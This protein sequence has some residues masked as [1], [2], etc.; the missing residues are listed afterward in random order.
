[1]PEGERNYT[2]RI[3]YAIVAGLALLPGGCLLALASVAAGGAVG[4]YLYYKYDKGRIYRDYPATVP[5]VRNA[6]HAALLDLHFVIDAD[7]VKDGNALV[8]TKTSGGKKV[9]IHIDCVASPIPSEGLF[10]RVSIRVACFGDEGVSIRILDQVARHLAPIPV[11][12]PA[13]A[14]GPTPLQPTSG[15][16]PVAHT[17]PP[18][19]PPQVSD[20]SQKRPK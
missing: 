20:A 11:V 5:D 6:V 2:G 7:E 4:G 10:T 3:L 9:S 15:V 12:E 14:P 19:A 8:K 1:M 17:E 16:R 13:P 18:L